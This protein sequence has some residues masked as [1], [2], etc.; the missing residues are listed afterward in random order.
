MTTPQKISTCFW[1]D[2]NAEEAIDFYLSIFKDSKLVSVLRNGDDGPGPRGSLLAATFEIEGQQIEVLN[3]GP[4]FKLSEAAS[5]V[6]RCET[7]QE[8]DALW[9][10]LGNGGVIQH[11][12][13]LKDR[14]G[15][16]WQIV[17][18]ALYTLLQ[19]ADPV[20]AGRVM[21]AMMKM[22]K[23]DIAGLQRAYEG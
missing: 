18:T 5:L 16:S 23:M 19:D 3:G 22:V 14:F 11:C 20:K 21:K 1:F 7:Q 15:L 9:D 2:N 10:R 17:P 4:V 13:W 6:V 12:G 8:I